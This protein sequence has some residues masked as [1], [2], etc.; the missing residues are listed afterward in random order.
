[1]GN[2]QTVQSMYE[3]FGRGDVQHIVDQCA[4][5]VKW[6]YWDVHP[7]AAQTA[8]VPYLVLRQGKAGV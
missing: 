8:G 3:A 2:L 5:D 6:E 1:M 4:E 7:S